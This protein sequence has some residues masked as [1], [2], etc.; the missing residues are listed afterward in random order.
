LN[1]SVSIVAVILPVSPTATAHCLYA[2]RPLGAEQAP[3]RAGHD[4]P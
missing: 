1:S 4:W 3:G 2:R